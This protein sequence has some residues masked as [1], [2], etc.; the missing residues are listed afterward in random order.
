METFKA[1]RNSVKLASTSR[2][3]S[4]GTLIEWK[5]WGLLTAIVEGPHCPHS[6]G[7]L[8]EWKQPFTVICA[9]KYFVPTRWGH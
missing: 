7:T 9:E 6:L 8:I 1:S 3:H 5:H 2:P 4:L